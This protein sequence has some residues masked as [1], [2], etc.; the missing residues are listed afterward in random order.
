MAGALLPSSGPLLQAT[1]PAAPAT[2]RTSTAAR[3]RRR[4][5]AAARAAPTPTTSHAEDPVDVPEASQPWLPPVSPPLLPPVPPL[6]LPTGLPPEP[7]PVPL[8]VPCGAHH[9]S[10]ATQLPLHVAPEQETA[11]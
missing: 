1:D 2:P 7:L 9:Q 3:P 10:G 11:M 4:R 6:L 5:L 8:E